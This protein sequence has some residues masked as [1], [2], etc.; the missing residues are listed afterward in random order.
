MNYGEMKEMIR[1]EI[2]SIPVL[3]ERILFKELMEQVFLDLYETSEKMYREL[4]QRVQEELAY[5]VNR[6]QIRTGIIERSCFD[7][8]HQFF[9]PMED[10]DLKALSY[11]AGDIWEGIEK[12]GQFILM[13]IMLRCDYL[14]LKELWERDPIFDGVIETDS[15]REA[16]KITVRL[17]RNTEYLQKVGRLYQLFMKNGIPW[18][19]LNAPYLYKLADVVVFQ[20][21]EGIQKK[22][23]IRQ[24]RIDFGK[25]KDFVS[26]DMVPVWNVRKLILDGI[27]FPIP[28]EDHR[29]FEHRISIREYGTCHAY[30]AGDEPDI[31][32]ISQRKEKLL[33]ISENSRTKKWSIYQIRNAENKKTDHYEFPVMQNERVENFSERYQR[34]WGQSI[35]TRAELERFIRG[36]HLERY[37]RYQGCEL[38]E[39]FDGRKE[40]YSMN[41][42]IEDE[43]RD[44]RSQKKLFLRFQAGREE[45]WLHRDIASFLVSEVQRL[46]PGYECGGM[47][48]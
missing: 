6:Y 13:K 45:E 34:K 20:A 1:Q 21:P 9:S 41:P 5:D 15:S 2:V 39:Q 11:E 22:E 43:I 12:E 46:Y 24:I 23:K 42:F 44:T 30:L 17:R 16:R 26:Y 37:I 19:T 35:R 25:Y 48:L 33:I 14:Q 27:G 40:T 10:R 28:C 29:N 8:S 4:E 7:A 32:S 31:R 38:L 3:E 18:Q 36:F 47:V